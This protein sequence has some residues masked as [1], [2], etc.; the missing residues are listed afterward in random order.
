MPASARGLL[1]VGPQ[2]QSKATPPPLPKA[3]QQQ[4]QKPA[5]A[6]LPQNNALGKFKSSLNM[7]AD[8]GA[9]AKQASEAANTKEAL[10]WLDKMIEYATAAKKTLGA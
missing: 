3:A 10:R 9:R 1:N 5:S 6:A 7:A 8:A 4:A 2:G